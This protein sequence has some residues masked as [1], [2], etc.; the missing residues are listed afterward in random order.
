MYSDQVRWNIILYNVILNAFVFADSNKNLRTVDVNVSCNDDYYNV[1]VSDNGVGILPE[2]KEKIFL[3]FY[4]G[5]SNSMGAGIGLYIAKETMVKLN[6][7]IDIESVPGL[8]TSVHL[9]FPIRQ[10]KI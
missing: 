1:T 10:Q 6:G 8:G 4:R 7:K 3:L 2:I 5:H 9:S